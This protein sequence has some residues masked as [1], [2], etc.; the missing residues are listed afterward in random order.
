[1]ETEGRRPFG[2]SGSERPYGYEPPRV[3][4]VLGL[5][6]L[7]REVLYAGPVDGTALSTDS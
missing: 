2:E 7:A 3:E 5:E 4:R 1:M 6:D